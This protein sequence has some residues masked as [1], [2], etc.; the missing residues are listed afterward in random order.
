MT[1]AAGPEL[2]NEFLVNILNERFAAGEALGRAKG[3][4]EGHAEGRAIALIAFLEARGAGVPEP[5]RK[6][7]LACT[8]IDQ[9]DDWIYEAPFVSSVE[10]LVVFED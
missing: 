4:V 9:L 3:V 1:F 8:D 10:D 6:R 7:L 5:T 2:R